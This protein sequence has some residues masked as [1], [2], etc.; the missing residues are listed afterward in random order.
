MPYAMTS[1]PTPTTM[2]MTIID[3]CIYQMSKVPKEDQ[4]VCVRD[5]AAPKAALS[6]IAVMAD[7]GSGSATR[8]G[9]GGGGQ[10]KSGDCQSGAR[11]REQEQE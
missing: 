6:T 5:D 1:R 10:K 7:E 11:A 8:V 3:V 4:C 9:S 2:T